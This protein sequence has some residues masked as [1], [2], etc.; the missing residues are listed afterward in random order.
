MKSVKR[1]LLIVVCFSLVLGFLIKQEKDAYAQGG[2]IGKLK[3]VLKKIEG[4]DGKGEKTSPEETVLGEPWTEAELEQLGAFFPGATIEQL[5]AYERSLKAF[6]RDPEKRIQLDGLAAGM[7]DAADAAG[8]AAGGISEAVRKD[9]SRIALDAV[10]TLVEYVEDS[11]DVAEVTVRLSKT[12]DWPA[13][14]EESIQTTRADLEDLKSQLAITKY[15]LKATDKPLSF[16]ARRSEAAGALSHGNRITTPIIGKVTDLVDKVDGY[17]MGAE[18]LLTDDQEKRMTALTDAV[19]ENI[20]KVSPLAGPVTHVLK[21]QMATQRELGRRV[22]G[23]MQSVNRFVYA[24]TEA[25]REAEWKYQEANSGKTTDY[26]KNYIQHFI[27]NSWDSVN[28]FSGS[29]RTEEEKEKPGI[30]TKIWDSLFPSYADPGI[31]KRR[32]ERD[33]GGFLRN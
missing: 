6:L 16:L 21:G 22:N 25:E 23:V 31:E 26:A 14:I 12:S 8:R 33:R 1:F 10:G 18:A 32:N 13:T 9:S 2:I 20:G 29:G 7:L 5:K 4:E 28:P 17:L 27:Q 15:A 19:A 24:D 11:V 30:F 3:G